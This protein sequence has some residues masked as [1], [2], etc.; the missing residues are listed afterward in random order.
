[1]ALVYCCLATSIVLTR[2]SLCCPCVEQYVL[3]SGDKNTVLYN[4]HITMMSSMLSSGFNS[5]DPV[6]LISGWWMTF[7]P[8]VNI[9]VINGWVA[10]TAVQKLLM[11]LIGKTILNKVNP[12]HWIDGVCLNCVFRQFFQTFFSRWELCLCPNYIVPRIERLYSF[13]CS[14]NST[15]VKD[16]ALHCHF[17]HTWFDSNCIPNLCP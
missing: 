10:N 15:A 9:R 3:H 4:L 5:V 13:V 17:L 8:L 16:N 1:M 11:V 6:N 12:L 2:T 7:Q 14:G